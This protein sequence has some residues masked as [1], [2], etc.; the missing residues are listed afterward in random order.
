MQH[1][2]KVDMA[3]NVRQ[4]HYS[5]ISRRFLNRLYCRSIWWR[6]FTI[7][8]TKKLEVK[9]PAYTSFIS[10]LHKSYRVEKII[11]HHLIFLLSRLV[12]VYWFPTQFYHNCKYKAFIWQKDVKYNCVWNR[13]HVATNLDS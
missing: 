10:N 3:R 12:S 7:I 8:C 4:S 11:L 9:M 2:S 1:S 5:F 13:S 6:Y